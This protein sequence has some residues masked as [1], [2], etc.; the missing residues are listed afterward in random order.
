MAVGVLLVVA[1][2]LGV[3]G[4]SRGALRLLLVLLPLILASFLL[5]LL[6][7]LLY[8]IDVLRNVGLVWPAFTLVLFGVVGGYAL[9]RVAA[10]KLPDSIHRTDR[11]GGVVIG[12]L[13]SLVVVWIGCVWVAAWSASRQSEKTDGSAVRLARVLDATFLGWIP[14]V[15]S[16]SAAMMGLME[17]SVADEEVRQ[18]ALEELDFRRLFDVPVVRAVVEDPRIRKEIEA[19]A[20]GSIP[21]LWRLQKDPKILGLF[22]SNEVLEALDGHSLDEIVGAVRKSKASSAEHR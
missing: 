6:G 21:A 19:A 16:G 12:V 17:I 18:R 7:P 11:I 3:Y 20:R 15:G 4:Y 10:K 2:A 5:W 9:R 8:R 1:A 22:E 14:V 13:L